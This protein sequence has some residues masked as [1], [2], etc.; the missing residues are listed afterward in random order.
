MVLLFENKTTPKLGNFA[1]YIKRT[2][3]EGGEEE[4]RHLSAEKNNWTFSKNRVNKKWKNKEEATDTAS[5]HN[6]PSLI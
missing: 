4:K 6:T 3:K 5:I 1:I 2:K